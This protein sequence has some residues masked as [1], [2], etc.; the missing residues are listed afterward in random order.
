MLPAGRVVQERAVRTARS[1]KR[2]R[3]PRGP[4]SRDRMRAMTRVVGTAFSACASVTFGS[5]CC[6]RQQFT[7][8]VVHTHESSVFSRF[9]Q[10]TELLRQGSLR[11]LSAVVRAFWSWPL[12]SQLPPRSVALRARSPLSWSRALQL[13]V[14]PLPVQPHASCR[15]LHWSTRSL[16]ICNH[17]SDFTVTR[18]RPSSPVLLLL[19][20]ACSRPRN[21]PRSGRAMCLLTD[22]F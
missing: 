10:R 5:F 15:R 6:H 13:A 1:P 16:I 12:R 18:A 7:V 22:F 3:S 14:P 8:R 11:D 21:C 4:R 19:P 20:P 9:T 2:S 17:S